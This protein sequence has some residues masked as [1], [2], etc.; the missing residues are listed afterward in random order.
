[1]K[2]YL[3]FII[4]CSLSYPGLSQNSGV[5]F[6]T[7]QQSADNAALISKKFVNNSLGPAEDINKAIPYSLKYSNNEFLDGSVYYV[8]GRQLDSLKLN[9][10]LFYREMQFV[11]DGNKIL[12]IGDDPTLKYVRI[13]SDY[14]YHD[15]EKGYLK[16]IEASGMV[17]L[18][19]NQ[20]LIVS[21]YTG[22]Q[23]SGYDITPSEITPSE[24]ISSH[25]DSLTNS[26]FF[27]NEILACTRKTTYFLLDKY[28]K[29][30]PANKKGFL[31]VFPRK[32]KQIDA[33]LDQMARENKPIKFYKEE[34]ILKLM[35]VCAD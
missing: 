1:M 7:N 25:Y 17:N 34:D 27:Q 24:M 33:Y 2:A 31:K 15:T 16:I 14:Y 12:A 28:D 10:H 11:G 22:A 20:I 3:L 4:C 26:A 30:Y 19:A 29:I 8:S 6:S 9:Y 18:V 32:E 35:K 5:S 23:K 21:K 13:G